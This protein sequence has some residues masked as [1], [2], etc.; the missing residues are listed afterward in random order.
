MVPISPCLV[1][2]H[3]E[4]ALQHCASRCK[5]LQVEVQQASILVVSVEVQGFGCK[6][7]LGRSLYHLI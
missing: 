1:C 3:P 6:G 7:I 5:Q 4:H 2:T